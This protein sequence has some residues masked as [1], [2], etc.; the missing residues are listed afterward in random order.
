MFKKH[1]QLI[2]GFVLGVLLFSI[3]P[4]SATV[5]EY[6]LQKSSAKL[7]V[8]GIEFSNKELPVLNY[9]GYNYLPAATFREI[10]DKIGVGFEWVGEKKEIQIETGT[11]NNT[12]ISNKEQSLT[13]ATTYKKDG[14]DILTHNNKEYVA[15]VDIKNKLPDGYKFDYEPGKNIIF[16]ATYERDKDGRDTIKSIVLNDIPHILYERKTWIEYDYYLNNIIQIKK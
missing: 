4:V 16:I 12:A 6:L 9:K 11:K 3:V 5:Q 1:K 8:D 14:F 10:C 2:I 15:Y 13:Q 7:M